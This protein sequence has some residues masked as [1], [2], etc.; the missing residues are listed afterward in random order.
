MGR[1]IYHPVSDNTPGKLILLYL[2]YKK[3]SLPYYLVVDYQNMTSMIS[4]TKGQSRNT[5]SDINGS[6]LSLIKLF[7]VF[8]ATKTVLK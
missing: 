6:P 7:R 1:V 5:D 3:Y 8:Y 2:I 4:Q